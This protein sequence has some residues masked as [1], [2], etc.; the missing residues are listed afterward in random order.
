MY[1]SVTLDTRREE[2]Y[3]GNSYSSRQMRNSL[4][5]CLYF[6]RHFVAP[7]PPLGYPLFCFCL[8]LQV[9]GDLVHRNRQQTVSD[10]VLQPTILPAPLVLP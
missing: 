1:Y 4:P 10:A 3:V 5:L 2:V 8:P 9:S 7:P 6:I